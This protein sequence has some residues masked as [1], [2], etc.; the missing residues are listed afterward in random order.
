MIF[1][2][3]NIKNNYHLLLTI[4]HFFFFCLFRFGCCPN[5]ITSA[6]GP[7]FQGCYNCVEG[8][9]ECDSC[10][11]TQYGCCTDNVTAATGPNMAGCQDNCKF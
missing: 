11:E 5:G 7:S 9:G 8:S 4:N 3:Y 1:S 10:L 2:S 6:T